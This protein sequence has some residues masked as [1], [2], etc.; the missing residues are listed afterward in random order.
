[1]AEQVVY[2]RTTERRKFATCRQAW[3]W[4]FVD[5]LKPK[6]EK[7][8]L[9]FGGL[10]HQAMNLGSPEDGMP[11]WYRPG[12]RRGTHPALAF[13]ALYDRAVANGMY[14]FSIRDDEESVNARDL[15]VD[16]LERY[17]ETYGK[18]EHL[19]VI[20]PEMT[21]QVPLNKTNGKPLM[22]RQPDGSLRRAV[23][24]GTTDI[25]VYDL[26]RDQVGVVETKTAAS[27][28]DRHLGYDEQAGSYW[29]FVPI[30][31]RNYLRKL[32]KDDIDF[33]M[34]NFLR[35][36][37]RDERPENEAGL[38]L[39]Q[40]SKKALQA[41]AA[42]LGIT[43]AKSATMDEYVFALGARGVN[44][45]LLG[46]V[47]KSQPPPFF[48]RVKAWRHEV[49]KANL[50]YRVQAQTWEMGQVRLGE[51]PVYKNPAGT[52]PDQHCNACGFRD[53]CQL[54]EAGSDW[55]ELRD[56]TMTTWDPYEDHR[57]K[58]SE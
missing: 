51:L 11:A 37:M 42:E 9:T 27:I 30:A 14:D 17:V 52:W 32:K 12:V 57:P 40:P 38:K 22:I 43:I 15:G 35:K 53:M 44:V 36:A 23:Y 56:L 55:E 20:A 6:E 16:M 19:R 21:F 18:D 34:Y 7:P 49:S 58:E 5:C 26:E 2:V 47:S 10:V 41:K 50:M 25:L 4:E 29:L 54:H 33:L 28:S 1:M 39:N 46:E 24:V 13:A 48:R 45:P 8:A 3:W 31:L